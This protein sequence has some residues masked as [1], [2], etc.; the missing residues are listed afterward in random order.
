MMTA[1]FDG[2]RSAVPLRSI[3]LTIGRER[4]TGGL[5]G[6]QGDTDRF[7]GASTA[8]GDLNGDGTLD[9]VV[10]ADGDDDGGTNRGAAP[11]TCCSWTAT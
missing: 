3:D 10:G 4:S 2:P 6:P 7:G 5:T 9:L 8:V 1:R 11:S